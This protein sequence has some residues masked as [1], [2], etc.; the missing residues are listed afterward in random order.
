M[1]RI[2]CFPEYRGQTTDY[3]LCASSPDNDTCT[4]D[5]GGPIYAQSGTVAALSAWADGDARHFCGDLTQGVLVAPQRG[6][7][8]SVLRGWGE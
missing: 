5:S 4:G 8:D 1:R 7:I 3:Q 2:L 6:W